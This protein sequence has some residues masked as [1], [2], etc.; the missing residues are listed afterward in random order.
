MRADA[1]PRPRD[2]ILMLIGVLLVLFLL[3]R[4]PL[5]GGVL[6]FLLIIAGIGSVVMASAQRHR[7]ETATATTP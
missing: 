2:R 7:G 4:I 3:T 1:Q 6:R 5:L